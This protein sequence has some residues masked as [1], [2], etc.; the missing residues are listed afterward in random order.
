MVWT[1]LTTGLFLT[2]FVLDLFLVVTMLNTRMS[3][4]IRD[5]LAR[6]TF[7]GIY[8][9][10]F[11]LVVVGCALRE[12]EH[13]NLPYCFIHGWPSDLFWAT[14][15]ISLVVDIG[16]FAWI[17]RTIIVSFN[18]VTSTSSGNGPSPRS[19]A[20]QYRRPILVTFL[21]IILF[22]IAVVF[23]IQVFLYSDEWR[24]GTVQWF[25]CNLVYTHTEGAQC[26]EYPPGP[27]HG[28][29]WLTFFVIFCQGLIIS[30]I[31]GV[32]AQNFRLW[33]ELVF[34]RILPRL[35]ITRYVDRAESTSNHT[36]RS[37]PHLRQKS[38]VHTTRDSTHGDQSNESQAPA[39]VLAKTA[40][41]GEDAPVRGRAGSLFL[42]A[43]SNTEFVPFD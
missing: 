3:K 16:L 20:M 42:P 38:S 19:V 43:S 21:C 15:C 31:F 8:G 13:D 40:S 35:G 29:L 6:G 24:A 32:S 7:I 27:D 34:N 11:L 10:T 36:S 9:Y 26:G 33:K 4:E 17:C 23:R 37:N 18:R 30:S 12:L 39:P 1:T 41:G 2:A 25:L 22:F 14:L 28:F 5:R